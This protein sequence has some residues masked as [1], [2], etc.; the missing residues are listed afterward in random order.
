MANP[1]TSTFPYAIPTDSIL[2]VASDNAQS[3]LTADIDDTQTSIPVSDGSVFETPCLIGIDD[4][5]IS[6]AGRS[7]NNLTPCIR[8]VSGTTAVAHT[9][10][11]P[12]LGYVFAYHHNQVAAEIQSLSG[13]TFQNAMRGLDRLENLLSYSE[14][15]ENVAWNKYTGTTVPA[16]N[17]AAPN[18]TNTGRRLLEGSGSGR[19]GVGASYSTLTDGTAIVISVYAKKQSLDW[20][21][22]GQNINGETGRRAWFNINTGTIGTVGA[23]AKATIVD[24]G[25]GWY[26]CLVETT[27]TTNVTK[28]FDIVMTTGDS[29]VTYNGTSTNATYFWGAQVRQGTMNEKQQYVVTTGTTVSVQQGGIVLDEGDLS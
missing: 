29:T 13:F 19:H 4:E 2:M 15:L 16:T 5:I 10:N 22:I 27:Q 14:E 12:V 20:I 8:G 3:P 11:T 9:D 24:V 23:S 25:N 17:I 18:G 26:R 21:C 28:T 6:V 7:G 1:N